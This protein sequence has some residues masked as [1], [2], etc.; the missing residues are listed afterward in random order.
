M[1]NSLKRLAAILLTLV[2]LVGCASALAETTAFEQNLKQRIAQTDLTKQQLV[3]TGEKELFGSEFTVSAQSVNGVMDCLIQ[4]NGTNVEVQTDGQTLWV[5]ANGQVYAMSM[6]DLAHLA[7]DFLY[8]N[9]V[10]R[11]LNDTSYMFRTTLG[12]RNMV[13]AAFGQGFTVSE[14]GKTI[15]VNLT[16]RQVLDGLADWLD[17][18]AENSTMLDDRDFHIIGLFYSAYSNLSGVKSD[19]PERD[20]VDAFKT[21]LHQLASQL[22]KTETDL[23]ITG[24]VVSDETGATGNLVIT[25][26][27]QPANLDFAGK[28]EGDKGSF[29]LSLY[30]ETA[31]ALSLEASWYTMGGTTYA[32][33]ALNAPV[34]NA[35][36]RFNLTLGRESLRAELTASSNGNT[37]LNATLNG[38]SNRDGLSFTLNAGNGYSQ[39]LYMDGFFG[40]NYGTLNIKAP[41][42]SL[43]ASL[44]EDAKGRHPWSLNVSSGSGYYAQ[45][46]ALEWDGETLTVDSGYAKETFHG[47][48][49]SDMEYAIDVTVTS[50]YATDPQEIAI[51]L[52]LTDGE[53]GTWKL[54]A[55]G[56]MGEQV[57][58]GMVIET[59][60]QRAQ[61][62]LAGKVTQTLTEQ[63]I[64]NLYFSVLFARPSYS[65]GY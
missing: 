58:H 57:Q 41:S 19:D 2:M 1:K 46:F 40:N 42:F 51:L 11:N 53:D 14:D 6:S 63:D 38:T 15:T 35:S 12:L 13:N 26:N 65:Y 3:L 60:A 50:Q 9:P 37:V 4:A 22:R 21:A 33:V 48:E 47:R 39:V 17:G 25:V 7:E 56:Q 18:E 64:V 49:I 34:A 44:A 31:T 10:F 61:E 52:T 30:N 8:L 45:A 62:A 24:T 59:T 28:Q 5:S 36:I 55:N 27:N 54:E 32:D 20:G 43:K 29:T 23:T 16:A